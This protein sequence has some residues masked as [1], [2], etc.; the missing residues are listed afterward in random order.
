[1]RGEKIHK[2]QLEIVNVAISFYNPY[3]KL[4]FPEIKFN[5]T[6]EEKNRMDCHCT[7]GYNQ[8]EATRVPGIVSRVR[9]RTH[10]HLGLS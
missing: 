4:T 3:G 5:K 6:G 2:Q 1:M 7:V 9:G 10:T 8:I